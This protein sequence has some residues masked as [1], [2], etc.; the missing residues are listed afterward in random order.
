MKTPKRLWTPKRYCL[1]SV[2][3]SFSDH[4]TSN[5]F[6]FSSHFSDNV[7]LAQLSVVSDDL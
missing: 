4:R 6:M 5:A 2:T 3:S 7:Q 1:T